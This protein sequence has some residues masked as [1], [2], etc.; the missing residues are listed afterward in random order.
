MSLIYHPKF[1]Y[2]INICFSLYNFIWYFLPSATISAIPL[3]SATKD[4]GIK[5]AIND[6]NRNPAADG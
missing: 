1:F 6:S 5:P 3:S 2:Y 4:L